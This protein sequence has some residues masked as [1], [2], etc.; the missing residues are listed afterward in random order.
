MAKHLDTTI[1]I[2][3]HPFPLRVHVERRANVR[4]AIG[5]K[6]I[7]LRLPTGLSAKQIDGY[8]DW[9]E[10]WI[11]KQYYADD[12]LKSRFIPKSY[13]SGDTLELLGREYTIYIQY[14]DRKSH[15]GKIEGT[16]I[17]LKLSRLDKDIN[18]QRAIKQLLSRLVSH[19]FL[20]FIKKRVFELND[21][22]FQKPITDVKMKYNSSNWGSCSSKGNVNLSSRLLFAPLDVIDYV[23]VHELAHLIEMNHSNRFWSIVANIMPNYKEKEKW[24]K[25]NSSKCDF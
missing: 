10:E 5:K 24:L 8:M 15:G 11:E 25:V 20:P 14:E 21:R 2:E 4:I 6:H 19:S 9:A 7:N 22:Y 16:D 17:F 12:T 3:D 18:R 23:I 13:T 1:K